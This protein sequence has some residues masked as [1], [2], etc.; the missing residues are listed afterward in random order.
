MKKAYLTATLAALTIF[1]VAGLSWAAQQTEG[2]AAGQA[3]EDLGPAYVPEHNKSFSELDEDGDGVVT[4]EEYVQAFTDR[5]QEELQQE[6]EMMDEDGSKDL[7][8]D[9]LAG[10][11]SVERGYD[12]IE[13]QPD[14]STLYGV[15]AM[16]GPEFSEMDRD[17]SGT[18]S[19]QEFDRYHSEMDEEEREEIFSTM[20][21]DKDEK[22]DAGEWG[23]PA[24]QPEQE[25]Q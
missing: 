4:Q 7:T 25:Q 23:V 15:R 17:R 16:E 21:V 12:P 22:I 20:D 3:Q 1:L 10:P 8:R 5:D 24:E 13:D 6:F 2:S 18:I 19:R 14:D 11:A 9:E